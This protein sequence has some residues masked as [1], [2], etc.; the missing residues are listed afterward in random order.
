MFSSTKIRWLELKP[1]TKTCMLIF[2]DVFRFH[3]TYDMKKF[4]D[5]LINEGH[6]YEA[7]TDEQLVNFYGVSS[8][9]KQKL[10]DWHYG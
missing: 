6:E 1:K 7:P 10:M 5:S 2:A 9:L 8:E 4:F 3:L